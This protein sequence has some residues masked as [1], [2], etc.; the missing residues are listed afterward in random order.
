MR[1]TDENRLCQFLHL[2]II[3]LT[4]C[5]NF[6]AAIFLVS[7]KKGMVRVFQSAFIPKFHLA[8]DNAK[9]SAQVS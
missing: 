7:G 9:I 1:S 6:V 4:P 5:C 3:L 8:I 2:Y